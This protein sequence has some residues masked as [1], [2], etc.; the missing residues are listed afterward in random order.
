M[1]YEKNDE[2]YIYP[3]EGFAKSTK[4]EFGYVISNDESN[5]T[6]CICSAEYFVNRG[7]KSVYHLVGGFEAWRSLEFPTEASLR[8][9]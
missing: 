5:N 4:Q 7:F 6:N 9:G 2:M 8:Q 1:K 3:F